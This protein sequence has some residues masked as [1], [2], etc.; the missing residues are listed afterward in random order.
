M[1]QEIYT[2]FQNV[3]TFHTFSVFSQTI[4]KGHFRVKIISR[5]MPDVISPPQPHPFFSPLL[6]A[7][8]L[9]L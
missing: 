9:S 5:K 7:E 4:K 2:V 1:T 8:E 3:A 6:E